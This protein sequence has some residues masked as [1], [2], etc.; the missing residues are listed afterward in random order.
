MVS[1]SDLIDGPKMFRETFGP[2]WGPRWWK[3]FFTVVV[4]AVALIAAQE[5]GGVGSNAVFAVRSLFSPPSTVNPV[6]PPLQPPVNTQKCVITG[7]INNGTQTQN[8]S[9]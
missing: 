9:N 1:F 6:P 4:L 5:I 8:C 7:S 3:A 2:K